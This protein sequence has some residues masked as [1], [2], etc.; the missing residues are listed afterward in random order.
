MSKCCCM[1][2]LSLKNCCTCLT[3]LDG[4][5]A[6]FLMVAYFLVMDLDIRSD[7]E[8]STE[9]MRRCAFLMAA[10]AVVVILSVVCAL[11]TCVGIP[12]TV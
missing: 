10:A 1:A 2:G 9:S 6:D 12:R 5:M 8:L 11:L 3:V 7:G 4:C